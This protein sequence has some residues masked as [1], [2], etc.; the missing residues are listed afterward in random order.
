MNGCFG[1]ATELLLFQYDKQ[2][3]LVVILT[4]RDGQNCNEKSEKVEEVFM[5]L[6]Q[7]AKQGMQ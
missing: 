1:E 6:L 3:N 4:S 5:L 2:L 7:L